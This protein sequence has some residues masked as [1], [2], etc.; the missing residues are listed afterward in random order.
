MILANGKEVNVSRCTYASF[1]VIGRIRNSF[2][3]LTLDNVKFF[4]T[5]LS[6]DM[7]LGMDFLNAYDVVVLPRTRTL[8]IRSEKDRL[9]TF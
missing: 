7:I 1:E 2:G 8:K 6:G 3:H 4:V 5:N 9:F